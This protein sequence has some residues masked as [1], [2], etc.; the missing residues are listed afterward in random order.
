MKY[1]LLLLVVGVAAWV[2]VSRRRGPGGLG[3][4]PPPAPPASP[5]AKSQA[6]SASPPQMIACVHCGVHLPQA[7]AQT[8]AVGRFFCS[9]AHRLAGPR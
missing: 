7:D 1:L 6:P 8:D 4:K 2:F 3:S 5:S 9:E